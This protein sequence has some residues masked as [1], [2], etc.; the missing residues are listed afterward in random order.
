MTN[1]INKRKKE[2]STYTGLS[3]I[4]YGMML[5]FDANGA[6]QVSRAINGQAENLA[7]GNWQEALAFLGIGIIGIFAKERD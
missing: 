5:L 3:S 7:N 6:Q 1:W 2:V 4:I